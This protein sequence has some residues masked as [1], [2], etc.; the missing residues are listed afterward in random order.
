MTKRK[1]PAQTLHQ[2]VSM[3]DEELD[4][5]GELLEEM[6][7]D[8]REGS[9]GCAARTIGAAAFALLCLILLL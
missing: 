4:E 6:D 9:G 2:T 7:E 8:D 3:T 1:H 5:L